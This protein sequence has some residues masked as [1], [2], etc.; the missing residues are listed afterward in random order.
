[1]NGKDYILVEDNAALAAALDRL[2]GFSL[3]AL[4]LEMENNFHHYG[5]HVA[6]IQIS[7]PDD[8]NFVVDPLA[9]MDLTPLGRLLIDP[10]VELILHDSDFDRRTCWEKLGWRLT[11]LFDTKVAAQLC[12]IRQFGLGPLLADFFN[13]VTNKRFQRFDWLR[14]PLREDALEYAISDTRHLFELRR[15][16]LE[17]LVL[18]KRVEW[19]K[20]ECARQEQDVAPHNRPAAHFRIK[21]SAKLTGRQLAVLAAMAEFR[22]KLAMRMDQ[23]PAFVISDRRLMEWAV[24][25]PASIKA[26][27]GT[28]SLPKM[29][30][31]AENA[32]TL[33]QAIKNGMHAIE[34]QHPK[35]Q[36]HL[37]P[38]ARDHDKRYKAMQQWR[39]EKAALLD[40]EPYLILPN[41]ALAWRARHPNK[42]FPAD[43][44]SQTRNWQRN[45]LW[46]DFEAAFPE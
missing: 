37:I 26:I 5:L 6:L 16:L 34:E 18:L 15:V 27:R 23:P 13:V 46:A 25:P 1:M 12:G 32:A 42:P 22:E 20:E 33:L 41:D 40:L 4:D 35:W 17:K 30:Y 7:A 31:R 19:L 29:L 3:L 11:N 8:A 45:L 43:V 9:N 14:R 10:K 36:R 44:L 39:A 28:P 38:P 21:G 24:T 2:R